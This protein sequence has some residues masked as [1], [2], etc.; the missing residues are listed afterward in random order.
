MLFCSGSA[1]SREPPLETPRSSSSTSNSSVCELD[2]N[3][4]IGVRCNLVPDVTHVSFVGEE[5]LRLGD[6]EEGPQK[7]EVDDGGE[8]GEVE[9]GGE[10][11]QTES[12]H[13]LV[14]EDDAARGLEDVE[15]EEVGHVLVEA[16]LCRE[17]EHVSAGEEG[18][19][20]DEEIEGGERDGADEPEDGPAVTKEVEVEAGDAEVLVWRGQ[21]Q[22]ALGQGEQP[23]QDSRRDD[24]PPDA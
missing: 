2:F 22:D 9:E 4:S 5:Q 10:V 24:D 11:D 7:G 1:N 3:E 21:L 12:G 19:E 20:E 6:L 23:G 16:P 14:V 15:E 17:R 8:S 13:V 18:K